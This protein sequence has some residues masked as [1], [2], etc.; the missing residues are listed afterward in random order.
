M[1]RKELV[2]ALLSG[3]MLFVVATIRP[4]QY[5]A[6]ATFFVPLTLLE[7]QIE[8][9]GIGFGS[10]TEVDAHIELMQSP[11][12]VKTIEQ[13]FDESFDLSVRK[14]RNGAVA[15]EVRSEAAELSAT[16]ANR[17]VAVT[18]SIKQ[19]MLRQNVGMSFDV[20]AERTL[21]LQAE[22]R[23]L[24]K[25]LD[26]LRFAA[27]SDSLAYATLIFRKERQYGTAVVELTNAER[28]LEELKSYKDAPAPKSY[29]ISPAIP[30]E[31][32]VGLPAWIVGML[33]AVLVAGGLKLWA[34][35]TS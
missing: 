4:I 1:N 5:S 29:S 27:Q 21:A 18:D 20:M 11:V 8:Q 33:G 22:E 26:S 10:P 3:V 30:A 15:V 7:K 32:P 2:I 34:A 19:S 6:E 14:T 24:R 25:A 16:I 17:A 9:N 31:K 35:S 13:R 23:T 12:I 28:K